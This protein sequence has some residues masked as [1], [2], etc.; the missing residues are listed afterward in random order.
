MQSR[1]RPCPP[2]SSGQF[3]LVDNALSTWSGKAFLKLMIMRFLFC[4]G[5]ALTGGNSY[6]F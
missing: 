6:E 2:A 4:A 3:Y 1:S 5:L